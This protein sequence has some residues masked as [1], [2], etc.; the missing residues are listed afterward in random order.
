MTTT[1]QVPGLQ[2]II[3]I[4]SYIQTPENKIFEFNLST[5]TQIN[6]DNGAG[7]TSLLRLL[8]FFY[9]LEPGKITATGNNKKSFSGY[10]LPEDDSAIIFD[11]INANGANVHVIIT[12]SANNADRLE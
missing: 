11:Y 3:L 4:N 2:R 8:P 1:T 9:G 10:Y 7:K 5:H 6:G 12:N